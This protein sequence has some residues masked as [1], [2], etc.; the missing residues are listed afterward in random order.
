MVTHS[1]RGQLAVR[2]ERCEV[3]DGRGRPVHLT[4]HQQRH[5]FGT[6]LINRDVP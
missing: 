2:L 4:P 3:R 5:T 6:R 1:Y